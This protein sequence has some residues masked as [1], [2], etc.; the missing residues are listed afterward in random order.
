M[1]TKSL[2]LE[3][4]MLNKRLVKALAILL[5]S[6]MIPLSSLLPAPAV[7]ADDAI[8]SAAIIADAL[9]GGAHRCNV[10]APRAGNNFVRLYGTF[11]ATSSD[12]ILSQINS[13]RLEACQNGYPDP[14]NPGRGLTM[15]DYVPLRWSRGLEEMAMLRASEATY[16]NHHLKLTGEDYTNSS[17]DVSSF[18]EV[19][20][21]NDSINGGLATWYSERSAWASGQRNSAG[22]YAQLI[23]PSYTCCGIAGFNHTQAGEF[24]NQPGLDESKVNVSQ[25]NSQLAEV[26][27]VDISAI[28]VTT[29]SGTCLVGSTNRLFA[30]AT[31]SVLGYSR[32]YSYSGIHLLA[33]T[34]W[35]VTPALA[36]VDPLGN[37]TG[38]CPGMANVLCKVNGVTYSGSIRVNNG[39]LVREFASRLYTVALSRTPDQTGL[40]Y[41]TNRLAN[42]EITGTQAAYGFF[43]SDE[44]ARSNVSNQEYVVRLYRTFL[45]RD[46]DAAGFNYWL[47]Y[48]ADG[49]TR[50]EVFYGFSGSAEFAGICA[51]AGI[52]P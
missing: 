41:W 28:T 32:R 35:T 21:W 19:L 51:Y 22:N 8:D 14:R 6:V 40:D 48:M 39:S 4:F 23:N 25:Y 9:A 46:P 7:R 29:S 44:F 12:T 31:I 49:A 18:G 27:S 3:D 38:V 15:A 43:F 52:N 45:G 33:T 5:T 11:D 20:A 36:T 2:S 50:R 30:S 1:L 13:F 47:T 17:Y 16:S 42:R 24:S 37:I 26:H 34:W 10:N